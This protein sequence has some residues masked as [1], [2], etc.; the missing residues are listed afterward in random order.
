VAGLLTYIS[1]LDGRGDASTMTMMQ[2]TPDEVKDERFG[3]TSPATNDN[4][5]GRETATR[6]KRHDAALD[7]YGATRM[8]T[9]RPWMELYR[10]PNLGLAY[11][12]A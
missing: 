2:Y 12:A 1:F 3:W 4:Q 7:D 8:P 10:L 9:Q 5:V 6:W 11:N